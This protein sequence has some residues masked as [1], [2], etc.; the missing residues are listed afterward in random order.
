MTSDSDRVEQW[1]A[2]NR[3]NVKRVRSFLQALMLESSIDSAMVA[4]ALREL[5][6]LG[7]AESSVKMA[8][9][10]ELAAKANP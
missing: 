1:L 2:S 8:D 10:D 6:R 7:Q 5:R 3:D 9:L 4:S